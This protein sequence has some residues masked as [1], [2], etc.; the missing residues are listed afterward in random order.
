MAEI[1]IEPQ[2]EPGVP[3]VAEGK[4]EFNHLSTGRKTTVASL[5]LMAALGL[6]G[7]VYQ[8]VGDAR[9]AANLTEI[10]TG[11]THVIETMDARHTNS[12]TQCLFLIAGKEVPEST[13][14]P[15]TPHIIPPPVTPPESVDADGV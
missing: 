5:G 1:T 3:S 4:A 15:L 13:F 7:N 12:L 8:G 14:R 10:Q 11:L 6:G 9:D 2:A